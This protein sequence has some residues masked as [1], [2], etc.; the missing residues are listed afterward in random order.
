MSKN[1]IKLINI[2]REHDD[3]VKAAH[4]AME[5]ILLF[6]EQ[7]ESSQSPSVGVPRG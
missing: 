3:P 7:R 4:T 1:E 2:I 5:I 6:L